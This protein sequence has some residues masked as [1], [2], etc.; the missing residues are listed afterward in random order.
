MPLG[1]IIPQSSAIP[2]AFS[3][4][5][6]MMLEIRSVFSGDHRRKTSSRKTGFSPYDVLSASAH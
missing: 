5:L 2:L 3:C 4:V 1:A 6:W